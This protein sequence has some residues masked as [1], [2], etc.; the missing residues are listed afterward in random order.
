[1][2]A[3]HLLS[4]SRIERRN[5]ALSDALHKLPVYA[6]GGWVWVYNSESTIRQGARSG[7]DDKVLKAKLSLLWTGPFK[8]LAVGPTAKAPDGRPLAD[9]LLFLDLP[10][11]LPG[12]DSKRRVSVARC[13]P[14]SNP[15]DTADIPRFL[16]AGLT[17]YVLNDN[18]LKSPPYHVTGEDVFSERLEVKQIV[19]HQ[20]VRGRGGVLA[21]LY[22]TLWSGLSLPSWEREMDLQRFR[23]HILQYWAG[24]PEQHRQ[25]NRRY[26]AMRIGSALRELAR[27]KGCRHLPS[28]YSLVSRSTWDSRFAATPLPIG[29]FFWY[30]AQDGL[31]WLGKISGPPSAPDSYVVRFLDEPGP[32]KIVLSPLRY[33]TTA[34]AVPGSWCLQV[35]NSGPLF[36]GLLRNTDMSR[37]SASP[38]SQPGVAAP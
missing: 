10:S 38:S 8:I 7:T 19:G 9:K 22:K 1:M 37:G 24:T 32:V 33:T 3:Q 6:V 11:D 26:R 30:K 27:L 36:K 14:C 23:R 20:T 4:V 31:W 16:P 29:A 13:K 35:H 18:L 34:S 17:R 5:S 28:G 15:H 25:T 21:V 2:R 12:K